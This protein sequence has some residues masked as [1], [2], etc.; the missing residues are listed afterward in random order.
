MISKILIFI[1]AVFHFYILVLEMFLWTKK[2]GLKTFRM[3]Q[4]KAELSKV[5]AQNQGLYNGF[6]AA[7]LSV[8]LLLQNKETAFAF[9]V[10]FLTCV[11]IAGIFGAFTVSWRIFV[12]QAFPALIALLFIFLGR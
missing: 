5:L 4:E 2:I 3:S 10:F 7:G 9:Q 11:V 8:G 12:V 1:V 6:L